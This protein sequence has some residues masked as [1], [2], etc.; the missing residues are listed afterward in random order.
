MESSTRPPIFTSAEPAGVREPL[1]LYLAQGPQAQAGVAAWGAL[2]AH[3]RDAGF[4]GVVVEPLWE[5]AVATAAWPA[6]RDPDRPHPAMGSET[7]MPALL[8]RLAGE[9]AR[10][11]LQLYMDL[12]MDR[13]SAESPSCRQHPDWYESPADD[14]A[15]DPRS[16]PE[17]R[18]IRR[19]RPG[20]LPA[21][22][23]DDWRQRL[24]LWLDAGLAGFRIDAPHRIGSEDW[25]TLLG[26][27][28]AAYPDS[29]FLAWTP[30]MDPGQLKSLRSAGFDAVFSSLPW[31]DRRSAWL[32]DEHER[33][34]AVAP[35]I[36]M[37]A[38]LPEAAPP[39]QVARGVWS[40]AVSG[41]G[42]L[43]AGGIETHAPLYR[44]VNEWLG[45]L[46]AAG[47]LRVAPG[48]GNH[49]T[50]LVHHDAWAGDPLPGAR[51]LLVNPS[52]RVAARVDWQHIGPM[53]PAGALRHDGIPAELR[54]HG[55]EL[56]PGGAAAFTVRPGAPVQVPDTGRRPGARGQR[57]TR[58]VVENVAPAVDGGLYPAK[59]VAQDTV[60]VQADIFTDGHEKLSAQVLWRAVDEPDWNEAPMRELSND[61]WEAAI[62]PQRIGRHEFVIS[63][64]RD[65]WKTFRAD[66]VKKRDAGQDLGADLLDGAALLRDALARGRAQSANEAS[67]APLAHALR[68]LEEGNDGAAA[69]LFAQPLSQAME[70]WSD[71][72]FHYLSPAPW[73]LWVD[74]RAATYA[75]WYELFPRSQAAELGRHGTFDDVVA[76]LPHIR[77][78]GF[79]VLYFP[80][81]HPIGRTHR[82]GPNNSL[83]SEPG[84]V[85]SPYAIGAAEGGHDAIH[86]ELGTL[87]DFLRLVEHARR[88]GL[89]IAL[90]F[91]I[92]CSP[93]HPWLARHPEW[94]E[95]RADGTIRYAE[96]PPKKYEDI[97][98][99]SFYGGSGRRAR[100]SA[101]WGALRDIVLFWVSHGVRIFRVDNP[102][103][104]PLPFWEWLIAEVQG[105]YPDVI[106]LSEAFTR[107]KMMYRLAKLGFTQSYTYFTWRN[108]RVE[109][110]DYLREVSR[111]PVADFF[112]PHFFVNTPDI[113]PYFLQTSGRAGFLIR[114]ALAAT[115]SGLWG[116]YSGFELCE[117]QPVPG[118]EE[119]LDSEKYQLRQRDWH[120]PGNIIA[121]IAKLNA[122][123]RGS[124]ALQTHRGFT[125]I[126][127][128]N[129]QVLC[130]FKATPCRSDV[131]LAAISLDP[132]RP[133]GLQMEA[134]F[135]LFGLA[136]DGLL[137]AYDLLH[138]HQESWRGKWRDFTLTP[139]QPYRL[140]RLSIAD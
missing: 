4:N 95:R 102:H 26:P 77:D 108:T 122:V 35:V 80:P 61:R 74:R 24:A 132:H 121:H 43:V 29:S 114:A 113:N 16:E 129:D 42:I 89:E 128:G 37:A 3:V 50:V 130:F 69:A 19:L 131:V 67:L 92:Q 107:P 53:L 62:R 85:G 109:L 99:V 12:V 59:C 20:P 58:I 57:G 104:K 116:V 33:L 110:A 133:Q 83:H 2:C 21:E 51:V 6:P 136:D 112:R 139:E 88:H 18:G 8:A 86:P 70:R 105:R 82:K 137:H 45:A 32:A 13:T 111:P 30:G 125:A 81:I 22:L 1:R 5:R 56:P 31:W 138:D 9:A 115:T 98:N 106:F 41:D 127:T 103:T 25:H 123:R 117:Y 120:A 55:D 94:F 27:L 84:D 135:W 76:R 73:P 11:D 52:D 7:A 100:K 134:P 49:C 68:A 63:A 78:M 101:L 39:V 14:P 65:T 91:A 40:A 93:D 119:Y 126:D 23:L 71:R 64:W 87:A 90:D 97:V 54:L 46:P 36:A 140:W 66:L 48:V 17:L 75:S 124:P 28:R 96:N 47:A 15:R 44:Q 118:K 34:R 72:P 79:D 10:H 60:L 38:P